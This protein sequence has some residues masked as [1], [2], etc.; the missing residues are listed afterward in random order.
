MTEQRKEV[1]RYLEGTTFKS[2]AT[3]NQLNIT[4]HNDK[5]NAFYTEDLSV[6]TNNN[7]LETTGMELINQH[8]ELFSN[9]LQDKHLYYQLLHKGYKFLCF[10]L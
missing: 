3:D 8:P 2:Y 4:Y 5:T 6:D 7:K 1:E 10:Y 9:I